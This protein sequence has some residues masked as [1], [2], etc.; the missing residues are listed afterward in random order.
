MTIL[1]QIK[2][3]LNEGK[4]LYAT[5]AVL[6][7]LNIVF[8][9]LVLAP[10]KEESMRIKRDLSLL[11]TESGKLQIANEK[12]RMQLKYIEQF[13]ADRGIFIE[14]LP[15]QSELTNLIQ[16]IHKMAREEGLI[17][18]SATYSPSKGKED[19]ILSNTIS[20]PLTG[21]YKQIRKF[22]YNLERMDYPISIDDLS[23]ASSWGRNV[24]LSVKL[25]CYFQAGAE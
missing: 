18:K 3:Y 10:K 20:F 22:I 6:A 17:I 2:Q 25:S 12:M 1:Q 16:S 24:S 15:Q 19:N 5:V 13:K 21:T 9:V 23:I 14:K 7:T 8:Y 11:K 4:V